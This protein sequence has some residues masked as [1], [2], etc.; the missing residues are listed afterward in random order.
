MY[1]N[2]ADLDPIV[3]LNFSADLVEIFGDM[4]LQDGR[5]LEK[6][7]TIDG[8][9]LWDVMSP[10]LAHSYFPRL[11]GGGSN[12][13]FMELFRPMVFFVRDLLNKKQSTG[14]VKGL[15]NQSS[16]RKKILFLGFTG[17]MYRDVLH[18]IIG[19][20]NEREDISSCI[21]R[22]KKR[23]IYEELKSKNC[24][25]ESI[26]NYWSKDL[27]SESAR[28]KAEVFEVSR[29]ILE[30]S[31]IEDALPKEAIDFLGDFEAL[32][33]KIFK[34]YLPG[35]IDQAVVARK[36]LRLHS[37]R[38]IISPDVSDSR[39]R[40]FSVV[41]RSMS[42]PSL[43]IQFGAAGPE[44]VE[45]RF[46]YSDRV[47]AWGRDSKDAMIAQGVAEER[48]VV[49]G[50]PRHDFQ[51]DISAEELKS[52][53]SSFGI[54]EG[55]QVF[56][57]ASTYSLKTHSK[58]SDPNIL[59]EMKRAVFDA[60][61]DLPGA[62][63]LVKPHPVEDEHETK[64]LIGSRENI[65][66]INKQS[67]IREIIKICDAFISFG[68]TATIDALIA[69]KPVL[70]PLI[71]GWKFSNLFLDSGA[72]SIA[73][74][75]IEIKSFVSQI[76]SGQGAIS[77]PSDSAVKFFLERVTSDCRGN[78]ANKIMNLI[79]DEIARKDLSE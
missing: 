53:R 12:K 55:S 21:L 77:L 75:S 46:L 48:I 2:A 20:L 17:Q 64:L 36:I 44:A 50:S 65:T 30:S 72:V 6:S 51:F 5:S 7:L 63:L 59:I 42:I 34:H 26:W 69:S 9:S 57:L 23:S 54:P 60:F 29:E 32:F 66:Q 68:S 73:R 41:A 25:Y 43:D 62:F 79:I 76:S 24:Q 31:V 15:I 3:T 45:W 39:A 19:S 67:D 8:I 4:K 58:Y 49:T 70:C 14:R 10:E 61:S 28:I 1:K 56:V 16:L 40:I 33:K 47:A 35:L 37:P 27:S 22:D 18:P 52:K 78:A 71:S 74:N 38:M 13:S 11:L